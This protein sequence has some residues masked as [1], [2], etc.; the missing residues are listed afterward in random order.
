MGKKGQGTAPSEL[1]WRQAFQQGVPLPT[2]PRAS[3]PLQVLRVF[4]KMSQL[5]PQAAGAGA[6]PTMPPGFTP[7]GTPPPQQ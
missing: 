5:F 2:L 6:L 4:E 1:D 3:C 7:P